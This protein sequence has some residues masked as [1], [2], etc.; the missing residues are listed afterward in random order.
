MLIFSHKKNN[1]FLSKFVKMYTI[2]NIFC[3]NSRTKHSKK[4]LFN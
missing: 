3:S 4:K 2:D 1:N